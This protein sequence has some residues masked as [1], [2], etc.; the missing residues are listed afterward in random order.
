MKRK[1][2]TREQVVTM[3]VS[4]MVASNGG[5]R[6]FEVK[7]TSFGDKAET[8]INANEIVFDNPKRSIISVLNNLK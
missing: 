4:I 2:F 3:L 8:I 6:P 5:S 1:E 7:G